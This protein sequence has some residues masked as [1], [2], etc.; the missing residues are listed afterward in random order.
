MVLRVRHVQKV[1]VDCHALRVIERR[2]GQ[3]T[4]FEGLIA[5]AY[6]QPHFAIKG[7]NQDAVVVRISDEQP[8]PRLVGQDLARETQGM[9]EAR[10]AAWWAGETAASCRPGRIRSPFPIEGCQIAR[11]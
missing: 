8:F 7:G 5:A 3:R 10:K 4:V 2:H 9:L 11:K 6:H 1:T